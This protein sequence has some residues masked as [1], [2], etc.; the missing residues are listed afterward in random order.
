MTQ[1]QAKAALIALTDRK[2]QMFPVAKN[3]LAYKTAMAA[4]EN[5]GVEQVCGQ[6]MGKGRFC[7]SK[8]WQAQTHVL[9]MRI[10]VRCEVYN[11][12]P[13]GGKNGD[14]IKVTL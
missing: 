11:V 10:G 12:A 8:S 3:S 9:L 2:A 7:S 5:M 4:I 6:S 13:K 14:R 1:E